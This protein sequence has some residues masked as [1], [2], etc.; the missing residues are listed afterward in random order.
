MS[1]V[2][3]GIRTWKS[4]LFFRKIE[5]KQGF[6]VFLEGAEDK[7]ASRRA[8]NGEGKKRRKLSPVGTGRGELLS[9]HHG[10]ICLVLLCSFQWEIRVNSTKGD[11][12]FD[13]VETR[14]QT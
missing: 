6:F 1:R 9:S 11:S 10:G 13:G 7:R 4:Q 12:P 2:V 8:V 3:G 14:I 5:G